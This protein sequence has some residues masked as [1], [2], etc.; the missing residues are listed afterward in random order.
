V[1]GFCGHAGCVS[2]GAAG[3]PRSLRAAALHAAPPS[4]EDTI[5]SVR[6]HT[7]EPKPKSLGARSQ[8]QRAPSSLPEALPP[9]GP[10]A[11]TERLS[12]ALTGGTVA[13]S[14]LGVNG[15][16]ST[17]TSRDMASVQHRHS[18]KAND[19]SLNLNLKLHSNTE[20][21]SSPRSNAIGFAMLPSSGRRDDTATMHVRGARGPAGE[22]ESMGL[23]KDLGSAT[24]EVRSVYFFAPGLLADGDG[25]ESS[26]AFEVCTCLI[27]LH[28]M[29]QL[30]STS[31]GCSF[32]KMQ[33]II[34]LG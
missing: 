9:V 5:S 6:S 32:E 8:S 10:S 16:Q 2:T 26:H 13:D 17:Q 33:R 29:R 22:A 14:S 19:G 21:M 11:S 3:T 12:L 18:W 1:G 24:D 31:D 28:V 20:T 15:A 34:V 4:P 30:L 27:L 25:L 7:H 23:D